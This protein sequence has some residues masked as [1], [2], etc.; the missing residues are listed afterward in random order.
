MRGI[1]RVAAPALLAAG[2]T[3]MA[4]GPAFAAVP[5][6]DDFASA[7]PIGQMPFTDAVNTVDA[8]TQATDPV[9]CGG[10]AHSVWYSYTSDRDGTLTF[11]TFGSDFDT[12]LSAYTGTEGSLTMVACNDDANMLQS[13]ITIDITTGTT[14]Y[15]MATGCCRTAD[16]T[17]GNLVVHADV[18]AL[19]FTFD[20]TFSSGSTDPKTHATTISGTVVCSEPGSVDIA[21]ELQQRLASGL[22]SVQVV[23]SPET[24]TFTATV[25]PSAGSF[26]PGKATV[27][28]VV[29]SGCGATD[30]DSQT[31]VGVVTTVKL[32]P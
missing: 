15:F 30:C 10:A 11:D 4:A 7:T 25:S 8:T 13:Q 1:T 14:Y 16:G 17:S 21:G 27:A 26:M 6:N 19:P 9:V 5:T 28:D 12:Q 29:I 23:C 31:L 2:L 22:F 3:I 18:R 24:S 32:H 20:V